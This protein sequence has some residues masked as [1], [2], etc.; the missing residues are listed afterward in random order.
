MSEE[1]TSKIKEY[2]EKLRTL[3]DQYKKKE[4]ESFK[5]GTE[6]EKL[7]ALLE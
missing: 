4:G 5:K 3:E 1:F 2:K 6:L 7:N